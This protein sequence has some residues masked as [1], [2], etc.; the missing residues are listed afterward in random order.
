MQNKERFMLLCTSLE[1]FGAEAG[2]SDGGIPWKDSRGQAECANPDGGG[3]RMAG[4]PVERHNRPPSPR[5]R[6]LPDCETNTSKMSRFWAFDLRRRSVPWPSAQARFGDLPPPSP[7]I[8]VVWSAC[9]ARN[10]TTPREVSLS[11]KFSLL[12]VWWAVSR[13]AKQGH[14]LTQEESTS[15]TPPNPKISLGDA[16]FETK[17]M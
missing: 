14:L 13:A 7:L 10:Q 2:C 9:P 11:L 17:Q 3:F 8:W 5:S 16:K 15:S 6:C 12:M 1:V 4:V